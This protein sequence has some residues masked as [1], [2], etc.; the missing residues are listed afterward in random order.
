MEA[1]TFLSCLYNIQLGG[2]CFQGQGD[3]KQLMG[4]FAV[5]NYIHLVGNMPK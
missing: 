2:G 1:V 3:G 4:L 5:N